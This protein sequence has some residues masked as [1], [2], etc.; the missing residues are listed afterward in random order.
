MSSVTAVPLQPVKRRVLV[1]LWIGIALAVLGAVWL[2]LHGT[3][4]VVA[5]K[6]SNAQ[7]LAWNRSRAGVVETKSGLQYQVIV[8]G[9]GPSPTDTDVALISYTGK[10]RDGTVFEQTPQPTPLPVARSVPGFSEGL[11]LMRKGAKYRFW[12]KPELA[13]GDRSP[14]PTKIPN[15]SLLTFDVQLHEFLS[16]QVLQRMQMQQM[17]QQQQQQ[18]QGGAP[19]GAMPPGAGG[20]QPRQ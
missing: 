3:A 7:F 19:G 18:Q 17:M 10:L 20:P 5:V 6:G 2:A 12:L 16:E 4:E 14:D 9:E 1:Y 8:P 15:G 13:Y 11:K